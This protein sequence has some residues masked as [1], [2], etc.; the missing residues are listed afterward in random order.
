MK[1]LAKGLK[2][3]QKTANIELEYTFEQKIADTFTEQFDKF[4]MTGKDT[5]EEMTKWLMTQYLD[6]LGTNPLEEVQEEMVFFRSS[7]TGSCLREQTMKAIDFLEGTRQ[8]DYQGHKMPYQTRWTALGTK[9]GDMMQEFVL[10]MEKHYER[11]VGEPCAF[12]FERDNEGHPMFEQF[13]T[14]YK[15]FESGNIKWATGGSVDGIMIFTDPDDGK[16][17]RVGL[18]IKSKQT[19]SARTSLYSMKEPDKKHVLQ[20]TNYANL[21][22]L[23][24]YLIVY[25]NTSHK[26]WVYTPEDYRKSPDFRVFGLNISTM[27]KK[28]AM[29]RFWEAMENAHAGTFPPLDLNAWTFNDYKYACAKSLTDKEL[30]HLEELAV[31]KFQ[32]QALAEIHEILEET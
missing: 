6:V 31:T 11:L 29:N 5:D 27:D 24:Y 8:G 10:L 16:E 21:H 2:A 17:Y 15:V 26:G 9:V 25:V 18:E 28:Q 32:K 30:K 4:C 13:T 1:L 23:D 7:S 12:R 3:I 19:S 22:D 14:A 20:V